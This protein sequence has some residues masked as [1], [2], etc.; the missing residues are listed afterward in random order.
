MLLLL[1]EGTI[2]E[3]TE[4]LFGILNVIFKES[5]PAGE[6]VAFLQKQQKKVAKLILSTWN[7]KMLALI[8]V[9]ATKMSCSKVHIC[10]EEKFVFLELRKGILS[11]LLMY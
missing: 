8:G 3:N 11:Q 7:S 5:T 2:F 6:K 9:R 10:P 1:L 4:I